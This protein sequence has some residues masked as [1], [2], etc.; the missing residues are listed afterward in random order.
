MKDALN[1]VQSILVLGGGSDIAVETVKKMVGARGAK[2]VLAGRKPENLKAKSAEIELMGGKVETAKFDALDFA[3]HASFVDDVFTKHGPFDVVIAAFGVLGDQA[4]DAANPLSAVEV[5]QANYTGSVSV[6]L[7]VSQKL[8][9]QGR[10]TIVVISS[11]AGE[12]AR[13]DNFIY[14]STKAGLDAFAQGLGDSL[15]GTG[16]NVLVVRPGFVRSKMTSHMDDRP[17]ATTPEAVADV[18]VKGLNSGAHTVWAPAQ[19]QFVFMVMRHLPR[20]IFRRLKA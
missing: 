11:V 12:R 6:L 19:I 5:V 20:M 3:S 14:G 15:Q 17:M 18:I 4:K 2:V 7:S 9:Q 8:Q 10:G 16:V 13:A 1:T